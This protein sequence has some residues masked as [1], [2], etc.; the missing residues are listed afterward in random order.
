M[1]TDVVTTKESAKKDIKGALV[2]LL[3]IVAAGFILNII[4]PNL[5]NFQLRFDRPEAT[6]FTNPFAETGSNAAATTAQSIADSVVANHSCA[7]SSTPVP[8]PSGQ[9]Q[10]TTLDA[11]ACTNDE[12]R[13]ALID[14]FNECSENGGTFANG[15]TGSKIGS[16]VIPIPGAGSAADFGSDLTDSLVEGVEVGPQHITQN[17]STISTNVDGACEEHVAGFSG[18]QQR[19]LYNSCVND[20]TSRIRTNC[21]G[22]GL[23]NVNGDYG[24]FDGGDPTA[25]TCQLPS[26]VASISSLEDAFDEWQ[27]ADRSRR[28]E[29]IDDLSDDHE[30]AVCE[31]DAKGVYKDEWGVGSCAFY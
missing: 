24:I 31:E 18:A 7:V 27:A 19:N 21:V 4:N 6:T 26:R 15:G 12:A 16:C 25:V 17:G 5:T 28:F 3:I 20:V 10:G 30:E 14:Y 11:T 23:V 29:V 13:A 2:G 8:G 22:D 1:L 9:S